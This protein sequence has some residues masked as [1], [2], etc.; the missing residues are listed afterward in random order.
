MT[1]IDLIVKYLER[2]GSNVVDFIYYNEGFTLSGTGV[3]DIG[4]HEGVILENNFFFGHVTQRVQ[5]AGAVVLTNKNMM[6]LIY[7]TYLKGRIESGSVLH[8]MGVNLGMSLLGDG[9]YEGSKRIYG[10]GFNKI[11]VNK[12]GMGAAEPTVQI[13]CNGYLFKMK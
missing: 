12:V 8:H 4:E 2:K 6:E 9:L 11:A 10:M 5:I 3:C 1:E 13:N 7:Y